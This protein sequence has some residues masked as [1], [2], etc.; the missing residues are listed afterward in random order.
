MNDKLTYTLISGT[1]LMLFLLTACTTVFDPA[2]DLEEL[3]AV[4][5]MD[6]PLPDP[7]RT[8][9]YDPGQVAQGKYLVEL[10]GCGSCHTNG[11][12]IGAPDPGRQ[13]AGSRTGIAYTSPLQQKNPGVVYPSNLTPDLETGLGSWR[14]D[15]IAEMIRTGTDRHGR[16]QIPVMPWPAY[17]RISESDTGTIVAYLRSLPAISHRVPENVAPGIK[18]IEPFVYFGVYQ[19]RAR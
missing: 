18:A 16:R 14:D 9:S 17:S 19:S 4:T 6:A 5:V 1:T 12:L 15:Q 8:G 11:A 2:Q 3:E 13:L 10:L 7:G